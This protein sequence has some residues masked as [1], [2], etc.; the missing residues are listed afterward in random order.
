MIEMPLHDTVRRMTLDQPQVKLE[1]PVVEAIRC[2]LK[3]SRTTAEHMFKTLVFEP[4]DETV[5][6]TEVLRPVKV[7]EGHVF[8]HSGSGTGFCV[9][10]YELDGVIL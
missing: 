5:I 10:H 1:R 9:D 8:F 4:E 6:V 7:G 3:L 2:D